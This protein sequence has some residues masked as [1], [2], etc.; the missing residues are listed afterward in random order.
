MLHMAEG[1]GPEGED[2]RPY[3]GVRDDLDAE[4]IGESRTAVIPEGAEYEVLAFLVEYEDSRE[5][6][7][8]GRRRQLKG[9]VQLELSRSRPLW[10]HWDVG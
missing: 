3:L 4:D 1:C 8:G 2:W 7:G 10:D 9:I 6:C 5:H